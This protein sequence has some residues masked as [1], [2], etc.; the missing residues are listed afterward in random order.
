MEAAGEI[1]HSDSPSMA[2]SGQVVDRRRWACSVTAER[3]LRA[4][5]LGG[6]I[7]PGWVGTLP[8]DVGTA[9]VVSFVLDDESRAL[10]SVR[11]IMTASAAIGQGVPSGPALRRLI[12]R[13]P[14]AV[15]LGLVFSVSAAVARLPVLT[16]RDILPFDL[17]LYDALG[18]LLGVALPAFVVVGGHGRPGGSPGLGV[19]LFAMACASALVPVRIVE[20]PRRGFAVRR[21]SF[22][23][24]AARC[25]CRS[26]DVVVRRSRAAAGA[27]DGLLHRG[28]GGRLYGVPAGGRTGSVP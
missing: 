22:R 13:H 17:A 25:A 10:R 8:H 12:A 3:Q 14:V 26:L 24:G 28:R 6:D 19:A 2:D 7:V 21:R 16:R 4:I 9:R 11:R 27:A 15:F 18:P 20:R 1:A 5:A 23:S